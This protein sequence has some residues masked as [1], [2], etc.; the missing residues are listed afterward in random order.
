MLDRNIVVQLEKIVGKDGVLQTPEDL[1]AYSYDGTFEEHRPDV[2]VLPKTT[3]QTSQIIILA[4]CEHI[5]VVTRGMGSGLA[6]AS[7]PFSGGITLSM[8]RQTCKLWLK[9]GV[10]FI[11]RIPPASASRRLAGISHA[12]PAAHAAS[13]TG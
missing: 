2:V 9:R 10:C 11:H 12:M 13:S 4:G 5:P 8:T 1:V 6:A 3:E 7:V